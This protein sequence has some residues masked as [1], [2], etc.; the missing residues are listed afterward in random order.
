MELYKRGESNWLTDILNSNISLRQSE[1]V[2][3]ED[4]RM[5]VLRLTYLEGQKDVEK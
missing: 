5:N 3:F 4:V 2:N 1:H